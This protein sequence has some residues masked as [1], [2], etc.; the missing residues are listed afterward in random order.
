MLR[1]NSHPFSIETEFEVPSL[2]SFFRSFVSKYS[3]S[4][5]VGLD[6]CQDKDLL[7]AFDHSVVEIGDEMKPSPLRVMFPLWNTIYMK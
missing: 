5:F 3:A 2:L 1:R 4:S 7:H 6:M